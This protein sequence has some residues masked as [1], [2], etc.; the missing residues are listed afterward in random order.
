MQLS[1]T[2]LAAPVRWQQRWREAIRDP[3]ELLRQLGLDP[4]ALG[5]SDEAAS[6]FA[7][8]VG[9]RSIRPKHRNAAVIAD[10]N[11]GALGSASAA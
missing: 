6:Q 1:A 2:P 9:R 3:R 10:R 7:V 8:R 11:T 4:V 5:V